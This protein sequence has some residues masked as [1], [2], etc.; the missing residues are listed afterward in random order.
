MELRPYQQEAREAVEGQW[1]Q[2]NQRTLLVLPTGC[3]KTIVFAKIT[4]D[5]VR[6]GRRVLILAHRGELLDQAADKIKRSTGLGCA[7]E[8]AEQTS[9]DSWYRVTVGSVQ[10]LMREKRLGQFDPSH[11]GTIVI[12]EAHH[13]MDTVGVLK[14]I[15][16]EA[17]LPGWQR[18]MSKRKPKAD[19]A[20]ERKNAI[21][22][23]FDACNMSG[24]VTISDL[25]EY[26]GTTEKTVRKHLKEHG[27][28]WID[29]NEVGRREGK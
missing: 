4:E 26:V 25:T 11:F 29:N 24:K 19:K 12:D 22:A 7:V 2:G 14:D 10:T 8:K 3:G 5:C 9:L 1:A 17:E 20:Q 27:G 23:A 15:K 13:C 21:E 18:A 16:P 6:Q 28:F